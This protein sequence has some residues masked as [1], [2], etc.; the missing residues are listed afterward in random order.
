MPSFISDGATILP[1]D[2]IQEF[3]MEENPKAEYGWKPGAVV[4][5]GIRS[6]TNTPHGAAY[7][8]GRSDNWDARN[9]FNPTGQY[10]R[11]Q[12]AFNQPKLGTQL[13]QFGG[14]A[15]FR[16]KKDKLFFFGGYEGLRSIVGNPFP[17]TMPATGPGLGPANSIPDAINAL[18]AAGVT[19]SP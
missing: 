18:K 16:I 6:G 8:F 13:E 17:G 4:N 7:A 11:I 3:N 1:V 2:A 12:D 14:V 15:G 19:P 9:L 5:V 10:P